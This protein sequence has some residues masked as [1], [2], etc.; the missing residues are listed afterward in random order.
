MSGTNST[1]GGGGLHHVAINARDFDK[2]VAFYTDVLGFE[3]TLA[4]GVAPGRAVML[5]T[6][7]RNYLEIFE[8]P[9]LPPA[10][11]DNPRIIHFAVRTDD[12]DKALEAARARGCEVTMET[13]DVDIAATTAGAN[14][15]PVR[16]AFF[17]GPDGEV[18][19]LFQNELT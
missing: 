8:K 6:G 1:L 11:D 19:E 10:N 18:V 14:P 16:I 3:P 17:K 5:D 2:S 15:T 9:D 4:W 7:Q 13:K 12:T